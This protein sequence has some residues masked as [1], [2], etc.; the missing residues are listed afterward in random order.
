VPLHGLREYRRV[1]QMGGGKAA[2]GEKTMTTAFSD[3]RLTTRASRLLPKGGRHVS[4]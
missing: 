2:G 1:D 4:R 3:S